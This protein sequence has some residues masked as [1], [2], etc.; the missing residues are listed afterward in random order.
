MCQDADR[1]AMGRDFRDGDAAHV[2][3]AAAVKEVGFLSPRQKHVAGS[4]A[5][6]PGLRRHRPT[7]VK[8]R[9]Q[10]GEQRVLV[11]VPRARRI[12]CDRIAFRQRIARRVQATSMVGHAQS[13][14]LLCRCNGWDVLV[15]GVTW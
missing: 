6:E 5:G 8:V 15:A 2:A 3:V 1:C 4:L 9:N 14:E 12:D 11:R 10:G 13:T 7:R